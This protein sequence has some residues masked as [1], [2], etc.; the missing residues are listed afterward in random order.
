MNI[1]FLTTILFVAN[2]ASSMF[3]SQEELEKNINLAK[4]YSS[5]IAVFLTYISMISNTRNLATEF[6][7][8]KIVATSARREFIWPTWS[9]STLPP[10]TQFF[11]F[12]TIL[13]WLTTT[14]SDY[15]TLLKQNNSWSEDD[16]SCIRHDVQG[17]LIQTAEPASRG[18]HACYHVSRQGSWRDLRML[19]WSLTR[20]PCWNEQP[21]NFEWKN[22]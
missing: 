13:A 14:I 12:I 2:K 6:C 16:T 3:I 8:R 20:E 11:P 4:C 9:S 5:R 17:R 7:Q 19:S 18:C 15:A 21:T 1:L 10:W 22:Y